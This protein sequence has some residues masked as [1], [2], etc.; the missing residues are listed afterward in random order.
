LA[1][2]E[3]T[4]REKMKMCSVLG[5]LPTMKLTVFIRADRGSLLPLV[6]FTASQV[7]LRGNI[8]PHTHNAGSTF[9]IRRP[10]SPRRTVQYGRS[11]KMA[12]TNRTM[13]CFLLESTQKVSEPRNKSQVRQP[14]EKLD[15]QK[16]SSNWLNRR[17]LN[18]NNPIS[19]RLVLHVPQ[20][21]L[22]G[23]T[24]RTRA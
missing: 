14:L 5:T 15:A 22:E 21:S 2:P 9:R 18:S 17:H 6:G 3:P 23:T 7:F 13:R 11:K 20:V 10:L 16:G 1:G 12:E 24:R 4:N 8:N 19:S